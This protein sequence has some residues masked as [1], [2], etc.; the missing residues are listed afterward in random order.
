[1]DGGRSEAEPF[2]RWFGSKQAEVVD[3]LPCRDRLWRQ[4]EL[5]LDRTKGCM[6]SRKVRGSQRCREERR[7]RPAGD[8]NLHLLLGL[9]RWRSPFAEREGEQGLAR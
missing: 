5:D 9:Q 8:G 3:V 7:R 1:M 6:R 4:L 2:R